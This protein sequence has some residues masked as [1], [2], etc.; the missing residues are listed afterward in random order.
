MSGTAP[1]R[2]L[3]RRTAMRAPVAPMAMP[4]AS[5]ANA[6]PLSTG[7]L[8]DNNHVQMLLVRLTNFDVLRR[9]A[10]VHA[11]NEIIDR[12]AAR[13]A[14]ALP[15]AEVV[16]SGRRTM[17]V[18]LAIRSPGDADTNIALVRDAMTALIDLDGQLHRMFVTIGSAVAG[19]RHDPIRLVELAEA[20]LRQAQSD[21]R[22]V[23]RVLGET[24][25]GLD[26]VALMREL[27][28][29]IAAGQMVL[30]Y[31]PKVHVRRQEVSSVE[32][33]VRWRHPVHG[34]IPPGDF[35]TLAE[36]AG[37]IGALTLWTLGE[38]VRGQ[39]RLAESGHDIPV[40]VNISGLL[41]ADRDF[42]QQVSLMVRDTTGRIGFEIT[43]TSVIR[44]PE[45]AIRHLKL[46]ADAGIPIAI[47]D[48]GAGLSSL[49]YLKQLPATELKIDKLFVTQLTSSNRDPLI[50]RSTIDLA[51]ALD[52][53]VVAEGVET[54]AA[55]ALLSVMGC[56]MIQGYLV[57]RPVELDALIPYL[58]QHRHKQ[59]LTRP[60]ISFQAGNRFWN[61][62]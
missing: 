17:E 50:V 6:E 15:L 62:V 8:A 46:F 58:A 22:D 10:G 26:P 54:P 41:L 11:A 27:P 21:E 5:A 13:V 55:M 3:P 16:A 40:Y 31:Q 33:L 39:A 49:A 14:L 29:A 43:E 32:A 59:A 36:Q 47:D 51:H 7:R 56:D 44:D 61:R 53:E 1:L 38:A 28:S 45:V 24:G 35:I 9:H 52:M 18:T 30:H 37:Q 42:V 57:S 12:I 34:L 60:T 2:P 4:I 20:A 25:D 19:N 48:Y 23:V